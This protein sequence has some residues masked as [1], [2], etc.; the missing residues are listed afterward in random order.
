MRKLLSEHKIIEVSAGTVRNHWDRL[1]GKNGKLR[2]HGY[3][4]EIPVVILRTD[5][6]YTGWGIGVADRT[7][8]LLL[9]GSRVSDVF[10]PETGA[11]HRAMLAADPALHDLAGN[12]LGIPVSKMINPDSTMCAPC[13][14]GAIYMNELTTHGDTGVETILQNCRD[15]YA[16]GFRDFKIKMGRS[17]W[18]GLEEGIRRD[19]DVVRAIRAEFPASRILVDA[20]DSMTLATFLRF[21]DGVKDCDLYWIEEPFVE[22]Y[23]DCMALK[24]Y[25]AKESPKTLLADGEFNYN[26]DFVLDLARRGALD[27]LLMDPESLGITGWRK[28]LETCKGTNVLCS[29]HTWGNTIKMNSNVHLAAAFPDVVPTVEGLH[30]EIDGVDTSAYRF[31]DGILTVPDLPGFGMPLE[32]ARPKPIYKPY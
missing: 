24:E 22:N 26:L 8:A 16:I 15:D 19:I 9:E 18:M 20:N 1:T 27:V 3:G 17:T 14:D 6:G 13:Y 11:L 30:D 31:A 32:Y 23:D 28:T 10:S 25:L 5:T 29:P 2:E 21:M 12:I 4:V 7:I